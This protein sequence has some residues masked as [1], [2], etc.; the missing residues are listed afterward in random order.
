MPNKAISHRPWWLDSLKRASLTAAGYGGVIERN[1]VFSGSGVS[2]KH[3]FY[4]GKPT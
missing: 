3:D 2:S 4:I 1:I